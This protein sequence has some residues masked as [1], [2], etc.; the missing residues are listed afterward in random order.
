MGVS[1]QGRPWPSCVPMLEYLDAL[2]KGSEAES[3]PSS[4]WRWR[5]HIIV[6]LQLY[7]HKR[8]I[9]RSRLDVLRGALL[10]PGY[11]VLPIHWPAH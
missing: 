10:P 2:I 3:A 7:L 1:T 5:A 11:T 8:R 9:A 4:W 6:Y